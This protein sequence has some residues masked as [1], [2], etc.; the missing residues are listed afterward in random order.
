MERIQEKG[1][2]QIY[3]NRAALT[4]LSG[5]FFIPKRYGFNGKN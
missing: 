2:K 3:E 5:A 4:G 1:I